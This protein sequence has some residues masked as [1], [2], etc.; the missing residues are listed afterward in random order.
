MRTEK[1]REYDRSYYR[2]NRPKILARRKIQYHANPG[3]HIG[4]AKRYTA[5]HGER[6]REYKRQLHLHRQYGMAQEDFQDTLD[7][8]G[9]GC[10]I[11]T[12]S[13]RIKKM[14]VDHCHRTKQ[15]RGILCFQC[16]AAIGLFEDNPD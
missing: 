13:I 3:L 11:C 16:N 7:A 10:A 15:V 5:K 1:Q 8:Q 14:M 2:K 4:R 12:K 9:G 6:V